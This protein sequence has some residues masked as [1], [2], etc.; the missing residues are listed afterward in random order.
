MGTQNVQLT[1]REKTV[2]YKD[3][4][5]GRI[6]GFGIDGAPPINCP[7]GIRYET[8][9]CLHARDLDRF[10]DQ[11]REQ[12]TRDEEDAAVRKLERE[13]PFRQANRDAILARNPHLDKWNRDVN[14]RLIDAQD[15]I[16]ER[17]LSQRMRAVPKLVAE[18][19]EAGGDDTRILKDAK[20]GKN[21]G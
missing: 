7:N 11:Y 9:V 15:K 2:V 14:L 13:R 10:M 18:M 21:V 5:N 8:I 1:G 19:Y 20:S 17:V 12:Y 4:D 3:L 6:L 16:Y